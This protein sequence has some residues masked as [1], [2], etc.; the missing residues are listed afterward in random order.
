[1]E[2]DIGDI[3]FDFKVFAQDG[4]VEEYEWFLCDGGFLSIMFVCFYFWLAST[5][6]SIVALLSTSATRCGTRI[7]EEYIFA[8]DTEIRLMSGKR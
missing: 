4:D 6:G 2:G 5:L 3:Q 7:L 8:Q 1:M